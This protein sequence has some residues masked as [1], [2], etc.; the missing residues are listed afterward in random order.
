MTAGWSHASSQSDPCLRDSGPLAT[1]TNMPLFGRLRLTGSPQHVPSARLPAMNRSAIL[2]TGYT[3]KQCARRVHNE[4]DPTIETVEW[5]VP[6]TLQMRFDAGNVFEAEVF[7]W[8]RD[9]LPAS[10]CLDVSDVRGKQAAIRA[11]VRA[12]DDGVQV[13]LGGWLPDDVDRQAR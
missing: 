9:V 12:M 3:A 10:S 8:L 1:R 4:F 11:T 13:I 5:E 6:P 7:A 2:L